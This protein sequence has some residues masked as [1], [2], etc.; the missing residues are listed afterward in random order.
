MIYKVKE[1]PPTSYPIYTETHQPNPIRWALARID[2]YGDAVQE[3]QWFKCKDYFN[4]IVAAKNGVF[5]LRYGFDNTIPSCNL[6]EGAYVLV[7]EIIKDTAFRKNLLKAENKEHPVQVMNTTVPNTLLL[8]IPQYYFTSTYRISLLTFLIRSSNRDTCFRTLSSFFT[9]TNRNE[10]ENL[11][12]HSHSGH[13]IPQY[14]WDFPGVE[15]FWYYAD[16]TFCSTCIQQG[17]MGYHESAIHNNGML[18]WTRRMEE[19]NAL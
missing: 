19:L 18:D 2:E 8:Y 9:K 16:Q 5:F 15:K 11:L 1:L 17:I 4:G 12:V 14:M 7:K 6:Q 10:Y 3:T 13:Y